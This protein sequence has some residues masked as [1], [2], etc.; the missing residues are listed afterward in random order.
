MGGCGGMV[1]LWWS[2]GSMCDAV[3]CGGVVWVSPMAGTM[4]KLSNH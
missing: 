2:G 1:M 4:S 3:W